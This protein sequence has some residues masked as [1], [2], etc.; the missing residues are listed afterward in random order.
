MNTIHLG[1]RLNRP[2]SELVLLKGNVNYT[3][4]QF[5]DDEKAIVATT[6][7]TL[8]SRLNGQ[9]FFRSHKGYIIN[10][11]YVLSYCFERNCLYM[12]NGYE[13]CISRRRKFDLISLV[14]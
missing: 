8:E 6:L 10:I 9:G 13:V 2:I 7:K 1:G 14:S 5:L 3:E 11:S 4:I 12:L